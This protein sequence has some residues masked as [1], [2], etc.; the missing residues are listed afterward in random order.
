[1]LQT[2]H[3]FLRSVKRNKL[4]AFTN[5]LGL[6]VGFFASTLIYMYVENEM[7]YDKFHDKGERLYRINQTFIWGEDNPNQFSSTGPGVAYAILDAI[8][9]VEQAARVFTADAMLPIT[10]ELKGQKK[11]LKDEILYAVDS[12]FLQVFTFP[13][14]HGT[15]SE[16]LRK[17]NSVVLTAEAAERYFGKDEA[18]GQLI[19]MN[20]GESFT[21]TGV[22]EKIENLSYLDGFDVLVS[23]GSIPRVAGE[24]D[25]WMWTMF[26]T[27]VVL[28][29]QA[30]PEYMRTKLNELPRKYA[31]QTLE[32]MGYTYDEYIAAGKEWNLYL[33]SFPDIY[34][35]SENTYNRLSGTGDMK[36]V[37]ALV[38]SAIFL[39]VLSC[40]NFINLSTAQFTTKAKDV[41]LRKVLG[42]TRRTLMRRFVGEA[43]IYCL[44]AMLMAGIAIFY[45]VPYINQ[46][47]GTT[48]TFAPLQSPMLLVFA[49][50]MMAGVSLISGFYPFVF[51]NAFR[52]VATLKGEMK[53]GKKGVTLRNGMLITQYA[54]SFLLI[55]GTLTI[56]KQLNYFMTADL[57]FNRERILTIENVHWTEAQKEFANELTS[58]EGVKA[59]A[60]CDAVPLLIS[61]GDQFIPDTPEGGSLPLNYA[62]GD[63]NYLDLLELDLVVG[64][65]F[66][67]SFADDVNGVIIN[68]TAA[69]AIGWEV[70]ESI[71]NRK[72][73]NWS[74]TY[75]IIGVTKDFNFWT[76][77]GPIEPFAIFN[78]KSNAQGQRPL[79]RVVVKTYTNEAGLAEVD[80]QIQ[81]VWEEFAP[82]RPYESIVL[83]D[84]YANFF[85]TEERLGNVLTFFSVLTILIASLGLFGIVV[86]SV[87]QKKKEIGVR[88][89]LGASVNSLI[90]LFT[91]VYV[92]LLL[93][94]FLGAM[95][96]GYYFMEKWLKDFPYRITMGADIFLGALGTLLLISMS[97]SVLHTFRASQMNPSEVLKD[98]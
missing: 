58:I 62:L 46:S 56:F 32:Y 42:S 94:A 48:L 78:A 76:L 83:S 11:F 54:L 97:I 27:F 2:F 41:A 90:V 60:V 12:N 86:F 5:I 68:Q 19:T 26:E 95:P 43:L 22:L 64:R 51:F 79:T 82:N 81:K 77:H 3:L 38:G 80:K 88:K 17:P 55:I 15:P 66:D 57:G 92:K 18:V 21:V 10:Y 23:M 93:I 39:L 49:T 67:A 37:I 50:G 44:M 85:R 6:T 31:A 9:E 20:G 73:E 47:L 29:K 36:I 30:D 34:L 4:F 75:H 89:V 74:G 91:K 28:N 87:E 33:Q 98:E 16:V 25:S 1:M 24:N 84:H 53:S 63:E 71:L 7:S 45:V 96:L 69:E 13:L 8:P 14:K 40:I 72:I 65:G 59:T 52:P 61:N 70:D 35:H